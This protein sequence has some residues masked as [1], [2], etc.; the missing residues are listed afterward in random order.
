MPQ[1][2]HPEAGGPQPGQGT[3][4]QLQLVQSSKFW[5]EHWRVK[6]TRNRPAAHPSRKQRGNGQGLE[7]E[8]K[9]TV[10]LEEKA[11]KSTLFPGCDTLL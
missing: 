3:P 1:G 4:S 6:S 10:T 8:L 7:Q 11:A 2:L 5:G 9:P